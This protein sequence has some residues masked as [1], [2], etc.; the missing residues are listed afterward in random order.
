MRLVIKRSWG[1][2]A[3]LIASLLTSKRMGAVRRGYPYAPRDRRQRWKRPAT[4]ASGAQFLGNPGDLREQLHRAIFIYHTWCLL[5]APPE[6]RRRFVQRHHCDSRNKHPESV[7]GVYRYFL[8]IKMSR[9][10]SMTVGTAA[11]R[12]GRFRQADFPMRII[13]RNPASG[14]TFILPDYRKQVCRIF[15]KIL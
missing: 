1:T 14:D 12:L 3:F 8:R 11:A 7:A 4:F 2:F 13:V 9:Q 5:L 10:P 15:L 6:R